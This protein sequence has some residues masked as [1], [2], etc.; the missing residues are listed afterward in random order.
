MLDNIKVDLAATTIIKINIYLLTGTEGQSPIR[1][2]AQI[3][4]YDRNT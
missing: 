3:Y 4:K 2:A 1:R